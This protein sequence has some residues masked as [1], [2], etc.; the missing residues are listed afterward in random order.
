M[1][2]FTS[3]AKNCPSEWISFHIC[4][5]K[6]LI[7]QMH[8]TAFH[9]T[10][11]PWMSRATHS[12]CKSGSETAWFLWR[13]LCC[14]DLSTTGWGVTHL[15]LIMKWSAWRQDFIKMHYDEWFWVSP[16]EVATG[17]VHYEK[18]IGEIKSELASSRGSIIE[19]G[20]IVERR[21]QPMRYIGV[22]WEWNAHRKCTENENPHDMFHSNY[23][24]SKSGQ[25]I[26]YF[27]CLLSGLYD[28]MSL[29]EKD[30][31]H[32][33]RQFGNHYSAQLTKAFV[34]CKALSLLATNPHNGRSMHYT[35][36]LS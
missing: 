3:V 16:Q 1:R 14:V 4:E 22:H 24:L 18:P 8:Q 20:S 25:S 23:S 13:R 35:L 12:A 30:V 26:V 31:R 28:H 32:I 11:M 10:T 34:G 6:W 15:Q 19:W 5:M 21:L 29:V 2:S 7:N 27:L 17:T 33:G 36:I 9:Y